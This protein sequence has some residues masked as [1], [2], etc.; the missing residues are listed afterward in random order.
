MADLSGDNATV[1]STISRTGILQAAERKQATRTIRNH[2]Q[3]VHEYFAFRPN[4]TSNP[5]STTS[6][7]RSPRSRRCAR[8]SSAARIT[9]ILKALTSIYAGRPQGEPGSLDQVVVKNGGNLGYA[10]FVAWLR[11]C[12]T[13]RPFVRA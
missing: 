10:S 8:A 4:P 3:K 7:A 6:A 1:T 9:P 2:G 11:S 5:T 12:T 13:S